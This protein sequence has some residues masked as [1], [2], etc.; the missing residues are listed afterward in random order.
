MEAMHS[1]G[2][3]F[4]TAIT[5]TRQHMGDVLTDDFTCMYLRKGCRLFIY[6][7]YVP[8][9]PGTEP[10]VLSKEDKKQLGDFTDQSAV[11]HAALFIAFPG[12]E[13][14]YGGC[15]AAGR[16][17]VHISSAGSVEPCPFAPVSDVNLKNTALKD[18]LNSAL[19]AKVREN[20]H[21]LVE[22]NGGCALWRNRELLTALVVQE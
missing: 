4:G 15:L 11:K 17:F 9:E 1:S 20:H 14:P 8:V 12:N 3:P 13:E 2:I 5:V 19:L 16:G 7:E 18:A 6:V 21:L 10:L 22:G